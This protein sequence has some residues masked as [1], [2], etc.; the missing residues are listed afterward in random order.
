M[1]RV[2]P[3]DTPSQRLVRHVFWKYPLL[4]LGLLFAVAGAAAL[5]GS[6]NAQRETIQDAVTS[7]PG[8]ALMAFTQELDGMSSS[9]QNA[10]E[11]G[12]GDP[13]SVFVLTPIGSALPMLTGRIE[14][15]QLP[16]IPAGGLASALAQYATASDA[17][18]TAWS[19]AYDTSL[20]ALAPNSEGG[21][22]MAGTPDPDYSR[23]AALKGDFGPVPT[24]VE[25]ALFL[26]RTGYLQQELQTVAPGHS[27]HLVNIWLYDHPALLKTAVDEGL[28][29]DQWG[30]VKERGFAVGPWYLILP[31]VFHVYFPDGG[32][33]T[34]FILWNLGFALFLLFVVPL[35]PGVR[36]LP[37]VL[38]FY[39][40]IYRYPRPGDLDRPELRERFGPVHGG[41]APS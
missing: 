30:M 29:D 40:F 24:L 10:S 8:G 21:D 25:G 4:A 15:P 39:R 17:Q 6:P 33:G 32:S 11:Y 13:A 9:S 1:T 37:R 34:G 22:E 3:L 5:F 36:D 35:V 7:D 27:F 19:G 23:V 31:A 2:T 28:T 20:A 14:V 41:G 18:Q 12:V 16:T 26:A 38:K